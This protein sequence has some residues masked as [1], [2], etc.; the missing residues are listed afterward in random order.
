MTHDLYEIMKKH[1]PALVEYVEKQLRSVHTTHYGTMDAVLLHDRILNLVAN[2][3][4]S[5][6]GDSKP[7]VQFVRDI[8]QERI[9]EGFHL[10]ELQ[11]AFTL[12]EQRA[13]QIAVEHCN[14]SD[15]VRSLSIVTGTVGSGKD[16]LA[17]LYLER[18]ERADR[19]IVNLESKLQELFKGTEGHV[20]SESE[21]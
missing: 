5:M 8:T 15:L 17:R 10:R 14:V 20:P 2:F 7:F 1:E 13:W 4:E 12:L 21:V 11:T 9:S 16:E 6:R 19:T 18:S 3:L